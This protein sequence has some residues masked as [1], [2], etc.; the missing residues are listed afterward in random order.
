[1]Q[2]L[3]TTYFNQRQFAKAIDAIET[4]RKWAEEDK[5]KKNDYTI[6][7]ERRLGAILLEVGRVEEGVKML[8]QAVKDAKELYGE[9]D[10]RTGTPLLKLAEGYEQAGKLDKAEQACNE[11]LR[12]AEEKLQPGSRSYAYCLRVMGRIY[13]ATGQ[14]DLAEFSFEEAKRILEDPRVRNLDPLALAG[15]LQDMAMCRL[16]KGKTDD[17]VQLCRDAIKVCEDVFSEPMTV[18]MIAEIA[19][20]KYS[21]YRT[22][23]KKPDSDKERSQ[24][25]TEIK[26][27][28]G[29]LKDADAMSAENEAWLAQVG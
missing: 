11:A 19:R 7:R 8:E 29:R 15:T 9:G 12:I 16:A 2:V 4:V 13:T 28:L 6:G 10:L 5:E 17:A 23:V 24:L 25:K 1:M 20:A 27:L 21:L 3:A 18:N 14:Y 22:L 26:S